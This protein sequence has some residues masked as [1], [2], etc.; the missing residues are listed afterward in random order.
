MGGGGWGGE[1]EKKIIKL[2]WHTTINLLGQNL[3]HVINFL[4]E[5][6]KVV[7]KGQEL[8]PDQWC[9]LP[10]HFHSNTHPVHLVNNNNKKNIQNTNRQK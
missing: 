3:I 8:K 4:P 10:Q 6:T 9:P 2:L 1:E 5:E 7:Y